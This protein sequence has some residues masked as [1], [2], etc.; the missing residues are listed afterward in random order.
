MSTNTADRFFS[1]LMGL[2]IIGWPSIEE[3]S[4]DSA[5]RPSGDAGEKST[6]GQPFEETS[7]PPSP[8]KTR[9]VRNHRERRQ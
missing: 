5:S 8:K 7:L 3:S 4:A 1:L 9:T 6:P 2:A